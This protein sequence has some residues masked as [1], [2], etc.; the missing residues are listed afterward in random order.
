M[1]DGK[2]EWRPVSVGIKLKY[3]G[4]V[5]NR[6]GQV[7]L[8][9]EPLNGTTITEANQ[10]Q[11]QLL[12][13]AEANWSAFGD[14][15]YTVTYHPRSQQD[16][17]YSSEWYNGATVGGIPPMADLAQYGTLLI[18]VFGGP[19]GEPVVFEAASHWECLGSNFPLRTVSDSDPTGFAAAQ[20]I[21]P[22]KPSLGGAGEEAWRKLAQATG[23]LNGQ[24]GTVHPSEQ[25]HFTI[26]RHG[27]FN[28]FITEY[29]AAQDAERV[30]LDYDYGRRMEAAGNQY[31][32]DHGINPQHPGH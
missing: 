9:E 10:S 11:T 12:A 29:N 2:T 25:P 14:Q 30:R 28:R 19:V 20:G 18:C 6:K 16:L 7:V 26:D 3:A 22:Q 32:R 8:F 27:Q 4:N 17:S 5:M 23:K 15:E 1:G 31:N 24:S 13:R 21:I